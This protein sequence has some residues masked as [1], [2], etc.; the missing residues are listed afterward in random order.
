MGSEYHT[1]KGEW[2]IDGIPEDSII[3]PTTIKSS[4]ILKKPQVIDFLSIAYKE[5]NPKTEQD[6]Y[7]RSD[8]SEFGIVVKDM[9]NPY[10]KSYRLIEGK[11]R[12]FKLQ[13]LGFNGAKFYVFSYDEIK[14]WIY[15]PS[16]DVYIF[17]S[18]IRGQNYL[19]AFFILMFIGIIVYRIRRPKIILKHEHQH[20]YLR[21]YYTKNIH[22]G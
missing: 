16:D 1:I 13:D 12:I 20:P 22:E 19:V 9:P 2:R 14:P 10:G 4:T 5:Y 21:Q 11:Y 6:R 15:S 3:R 18:K 17:R 8:I 7:D